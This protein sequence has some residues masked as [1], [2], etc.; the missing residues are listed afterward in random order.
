M[1]RGNSSEDYFATSRGIFTPSAILCLFA[2]S[3]RAV[4]AKLTA[5]E[6]LNPLTSTSWTRIT[7]RGAGVRRTS[8]SMEALVVARREVSCCRPRWELA[9]YTLIPGRCKVEAQGLEV[10]LK[11]GPKVVSQ[12]RG[13]EIPY[14][15]YQRESPRAAITKDSGI[16]WHA[17]TTLV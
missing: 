4:N 7:S 16:T 12:Q 6:V 8:L 14:T 15:L 10:L 17:S 3:H 5:R 2:W 11:E 1:R 9:P 13:W